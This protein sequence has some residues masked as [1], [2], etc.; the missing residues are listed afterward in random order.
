M[1]NA[2]NPSKLYIFV[3]KCVCHSFNWVDISGKYIQT[4]CIH[5]Y[6]NILRISFGY[7]FN[8]FL[9]TSS[10]RYIISSKSDKDKGRERERK[11]S[12]KVPLFISDSL[13]SM[14]YCVFNLYSLSLCIIF[15]FPPAGI[16]L[17][18]EFDCLIRAASSDAPDKRGRG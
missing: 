13:F 8:F 10:K 4:Y 2:T 18:S 15:P 9:S 3:C 12:R 16:E 11:R 1:K 5:I 17:Y 6:A 7:M 14:N